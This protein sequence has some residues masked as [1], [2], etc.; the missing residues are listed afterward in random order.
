[1]I[2]RNIL[3]TGGSGFIGSH[4]LR[5]H[6]KA[7]PE[8]VLIN[9]DKFDYCS[10]NV[11]ISEPYHFVKGDIC[12]ANIVSYT[13]SAYNI[14]T[15]VHFAAQSH[16]DNSFGN[17]ISFTRD[18]I[19]GTHTLLECCRAYGRVTTFVHFSTDE[20]YGE[21][22]MS[23]EGC[24]EMSLLNPTNPYAASKA[25]AEFLVRAYHH[26]YKLPIIITRCNNVYGSHQYP[27]KLIPNF[28]T[29][30]LDGEKCQVHGEGQQRRAFIHAADVAYAV[31]VILKHSNTLFGKI[32]NIG[33]QN[34]YNVIEVLCTLVKLMKGQAAEWKDYCEF[35]KDPR[36]F[37]DARYAVDYTLL[38][39]LGWREKVDFEAGLKDVI[40]W[41]DANRNFAWGETI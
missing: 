11:D 9:M 14:D 36:P 25:A 23:H 22:D 27:E 33:T 39:S 29:R 10:H 18:N 24:T 7:Y 21:V 19:V 1:M 26:S 4:F 40:S 20:V 3:V 17:S 41:Y 34:E 2:M 16:V 28:I 6:R 12:D 32:V 15:V 35:V 13:L 8:D 38:S 30:L 31:D 5:E 37:N